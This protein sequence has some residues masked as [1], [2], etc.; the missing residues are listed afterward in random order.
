[1]ASALAV[2]NMALYAGPRV[3]QTQIR[4]QRGWRRVEGAALIGWAAAGGSLYGP[5]SP[6]HAQT[7]LQMEPAAMLIAAQRAGLLA[8]AHVF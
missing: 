6:I 5:A 4:D 7:L 1:M 2:G 3:P 8:G